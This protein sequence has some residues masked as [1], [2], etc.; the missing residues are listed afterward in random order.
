MTAPVAMTP[1]QELFRELAE[2][3]NLV[4]GMLAGP[5]VT[6]RRWPAYYMVYLELDQLCLELSRATAALSRGFITPDGSADPVRIESA[7]ASLARIDGQMRRMV[8]L[9]ARIERHALVDHGSPALKV[10]VAHHLS[11]QSAWFAA[12]QERYRAGRISSE[13]RV[14]ERSVLFL[15]PVPRHGGS[16]IDALTVTGDQKFDLVSAQSRLVLGRTSRNVQEK[17]NHV[18]AALGAFL[19]ANCPSVQELLH[20]RMT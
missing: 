20:P 2:M 13:G 10:V 16:G 18:Y 4:F 17:L 9:L 15:D 14:L 5:Q 11:P 8:G 1:P 6:V 19:V 12:F 7:N 3:G